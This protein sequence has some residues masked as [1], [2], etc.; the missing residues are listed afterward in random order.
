[1]GFRL[2]AI[3]SA[4]MPSGQGRRVG[5]GKD[6]GRGTGVRR[7]VGGRGD[8]RDPGPRKVEAPLLVGRRGRRSAG[9]R[10]PAGAHASPTAVV[11]VPLLVRMGGAVVGAVAPSL[12][13]RM[14]F[15]I[16]RPDLLVRFV[17]GCGPRM[18]GV[19]EACEDAGSGRRGQHD[20]RRRYGNDQPP[21][22]DRSSATRRRRSARPHQ[23]RQE[24][25][26]GIPRLTRSMCWPRSTCHLRSGASFAWANVACS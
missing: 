8:P 11:L 20:E 5:E 25:G 6:V 10:A 16:G 14:R 22:A 13:R 17:I 19:V 9:S 15:V 1:M 18:S 24:A 2:E 3:W 23:R 7:S 12:F 26:D 4:K 21:L